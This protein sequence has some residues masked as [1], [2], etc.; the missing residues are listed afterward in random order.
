[1]GAA[2]RGKLSWGDA[3]A[4]WVAQF[5]AGIVA[6]LAV[7]FIKAGATGDVAPPPPSAIQ[8]TVAA[9]LLVEFLFTFALVYMV[10]NTATAVG[11]AGNSFYGLAIGFTVVVGAIAVGP[12]SGGAFNPA[13]AVG[14]AAMDLAKWDKIW[15]PLAADFAGGVAAAF[16][17]LAFDMGG[18]RRAV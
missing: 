9:Q 7:N 15:I 2:L 11:T 1:M 8:Y 5:G 10:L 16:L 3:V 18:D 6:A 17:F 13:V 12:V 4:Y 14:A